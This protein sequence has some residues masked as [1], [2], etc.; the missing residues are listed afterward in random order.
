MIADAEKLK[1]TLSAKFRRNGGP[2]KYVRLF[3]DMSPGEQRAITLAGELHSSEL[4]IVGGMEDAE[5]WLVITTEKLRWKHEGRLSS[6]AL[7]DIRDAVVD[8]QAL[9]FSGTTKLTNRKLE[10]KLMSGDQC[11][12][13]MEAGA[14][15]SGIWNVLKF[16]GTSNRRRKSV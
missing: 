10:I 3:D 6:V 9:A 13:D 16:V 7:R 5:N 8:L 14:P 11:T 1:A 12:L 15:F 4:A 2:G